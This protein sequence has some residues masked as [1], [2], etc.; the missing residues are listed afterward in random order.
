MTSVSE[1]SGGRR[2]RRRRAEAR[3]SIAAIVDAAVRVL[4]K[5][6]QASIG[7]IAETAG[8]TRQTVYTHFPS[9][10]ALV[11]AAIDRVSDDAVATID[12][13]ELDQGPPAEALVRFMRI[14]WQTFERY[15]LLVR[16]AE[17][18]P[19]ADHARHRPIRERLEELV[20]RGQDAGDFDRRASPSWL[21]AIAMALGHVAA[22]EIAAG[23]MTADEASTA[24]RHSV[25]R[26]FAA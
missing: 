17:A 6:P 19:R 14:G 25:L 7:E 2:P 23:R 16:M 10:E 22:D 20:K 12:A 4:S 21:A 15:P 3:R 1:L 24:L 13:A 9:R 11:N 26:V 18:D 8:V 5:Q